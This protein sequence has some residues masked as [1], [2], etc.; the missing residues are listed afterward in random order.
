MEEKYFEAKKVLQEYN[1]EHLLSAYEKLDTNKKEELL[2]EI[3]SIDFKQLENLYKGVNNTQNTN[4]QKI[5]PIEYVD[6][7]KLTEEQIN[8]YKQKGKEVLK[9][10]K[11]A[12]IIMAGGQGTRLRTQWTKGN[13]SIRRLWK[14]KILI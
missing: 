13:L 10:G 4:T 6:E 1:Q 3:L 8:M 11:Y 14:R 12:V 9:S 2:R 7:A 5:E